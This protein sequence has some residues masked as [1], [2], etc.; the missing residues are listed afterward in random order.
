MPV[1]SKEGALLR[2]KQVKKW[3]RAWKRLI[4]AREDL[5]VVPD[6][7]LLAVKLRWTFRK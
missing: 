5:S 1:T 4:L 3:N 7:E 6:S 2:E